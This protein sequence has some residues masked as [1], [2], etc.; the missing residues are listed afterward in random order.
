MNTPLDECLADAAARTMESLALMFLLDEDEVDDLGQS[1]AAVA[2]VSFEG[3]VSGRLYMT[4][5]ETLLPELA[6]N[7][8]GEM[9]S[10]VV[11]DD[12]Q[13]DAACELINVIC[14]NLL[15]DVY[16]PE[17]VFHVAAPDFLGP[18]QIPETVSDQPASGQARLNTDQGSVDLTLFLNTGSAA[19][20]AA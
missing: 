16:G 3:P 18:G 11:T 12:H 15:P 14:G 5:S 10:A 4:V 9:D 2:S 20:E 19:A 8:L 17:P 1:P 13:K 6:A 7:M